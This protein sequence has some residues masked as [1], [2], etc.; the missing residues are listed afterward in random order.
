MKTRHVIWLAGALLLASAFA[1]V[2]APMLA[3]ALGG[4]PSP[5]TLEVSGTGTVSV[6]PDTATMSFGVTTEARTASAA[7]AENSDAAA[8]VI[9]ALK[10]T[11]IAAKDIQTQFVSLSPRYTDSGNVIIGY[12]ASNSVSA[13]L[14][15]LQSA[16]AVIDAAVA[17]GANQVSGPS[18]S[19]SDESARYRQALKA[20]VADARAKADALA[21]AGHF[22]IGAIVSVTEETATPMPV[23]DGRATPTAGPP[24]EPGTQQIQA[25]VRVVYA[26]T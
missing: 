4:A 26:L 14:R 18:L 24:V 20:A 25:T 8:K 21:E 15:D 13:L 6:T 17:A 5:G 19:P 7:L 10:K 22:T 11:G 3:H 1:G 16:G 9:A 2:G 12:T 23:I